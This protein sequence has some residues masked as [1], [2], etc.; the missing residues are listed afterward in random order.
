MRDRE[1]VG[2]CFVKEQIRFLIKIVGSVCFST[3]W[4]D[5]DKIDNVG[6]ISLRLLPQQVS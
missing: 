5:C 1:F 3:Y 2:G 4:L 6:N